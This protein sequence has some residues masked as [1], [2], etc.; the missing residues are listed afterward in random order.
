MEC[1]WWT[2][3]IGGLD[4]L[5][6]RKQEYVAGCRSLSG[7]GV[8][9]DLQFQLQ[10][11]GDRGVTC[12]RIR[13][14]RVRHGLQITYGLDSAALSSTAPPLLRHRVFYILVIYEKSSS[15]Y[16][17]ALAPIWCTAASCT[18]SSST[19]ARPCAIAL[20]SPSPRTVRTIRAVGHKK[21]RTPRLYRA[22]DE[23]RSTLGIFSW[24]Y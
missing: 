18:R 15:P 12:I 8:Y 5:V 7:D 17:F 10:R 6:R 24:L 22:S 14:L 19:L 16:G 20:G 2:K 23:S 3:N 11:L 1:A 21:Q 13:P 9:V 4:A